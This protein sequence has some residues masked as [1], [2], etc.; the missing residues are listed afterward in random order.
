MSDDIFAAISADDRAQVGKLIAADPDVAHTRN[1]A[2]ISALMQARYE[3]KSEIV[4]LL[5]KAAGDLDVFE[6]AAL[7]DV[8]RSAHLVGEGSWLSEGAKQ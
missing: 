2:G 1:P 5:R 6:A 7:G 8:A 4:E 3:N